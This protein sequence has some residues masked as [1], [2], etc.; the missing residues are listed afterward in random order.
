VRKKKR[1]SSSK[2]A[3]ASLPGL[4]SQLATVLPGVVYQAYRS[5]SGEKKFTFVNEATRWLWGLEPEAVL[6]SMAVYTDL[7]HPEDRDRLASSD[8]RSD[9]TLKPWKEQYRIFV[10]GRGQRWMQS[11]AHVERQRNGGVLWSGFVA[12]ITESKLA[13]DALRISEESFSGA[14]KYSGI[15]MALVATDGRWLR[16]NPALCRFLGRSESELLATNFQNITHPADLQ[17]DM[18]HVARM[19]GQEIDTYSIEKRY[20]HSQGHYIWGLLTVALVRDKQGVPLHFISQIQD[21]DQR[22]HSEEILRLNEERLALAATAGRVGMWDYEFATKKIVWNDVQFELHGVSPKS[23]RPSFDNNV[24]FLHPDDHDHV[25]RV[26]EKCIKTN[27]AHYEVEC[28][29]IR[30]DGAVR[31]MRSTAIIIRNERGEPLRAVG[32]EVDITDEKRAAESQARARRAAE[33][34]TRAKS[35]FL[36]RMSHEIRTP[37]NAIIAPAHHLASSK[38]SA[39]QRELASMIVGAG[40]HLLQ[41][42]NDIL[43]FSKLEAAKMKLIEEEFCL[44]TVVRETIELMSMLARKKNLALRWNV[45]REVRGNWHGDSGRIKQILFNLTSNAIKFTRKGEVSVTAEQ[46]DN[47]GVRFII[48]DSGIGMTD[49]ELTTVFRPFEQTSS[50]HQYHGGTGLGLAI[51]RDLVDLMGGE[52]GV[53]S[54]TKKGSTFW[55]SLPLRRSAAPAKKLVPAVKGRVVAKRLFPGAKILVVEDNL[56]NRRVASLLLNRLGCTVQLAEDGQSGLRKFKSQAFD[57]VLMDCE[58]PLMD[59]MESTRAM[60]KWEEKMSHTPIIA[61]TAHVS[62]EHRQICKKAG[63]DDLLAKPIKVEDLQKILAEWLPA[64]RS[65]KKPAG[66][67]AAKSS[68]IS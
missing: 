11:H 62:R 7:I 27:E 18:I 64:R 6:E 16:A 65:A 15:G 41:I 47:A 67:E 42:I 30:P 17:E 2:A 58:M 14:W 9:K 5:P 19:L 54:Q 32:T 39:A 8:R 59:G 28:R 53:K 20:L 38:L 36:A 21:I 44:Q 43:D 13:E 31:H 37:M 22:K 23:Y 26:F 48:K 50:T 68:R 63:M 57:L 52:I 60:R 24:R 34:A 10:P 55:F 12:D 1:S 25:M 4:P 66:R 49:E 51:C 35:D 46:A 3:G 33:A 40:E 56:S 29:I 61:L 45:V